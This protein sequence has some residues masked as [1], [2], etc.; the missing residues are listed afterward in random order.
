MSPSQSSLGKATF[1]AKHNSILLPT[2]PQQRG[3]LTQPSFHCDLQ[4]LSC[5]TQKNY[6]TTAT[7]IGAP[8]PD[9][10]AHAQKRR[11]W[12]WS[13]F[14]KK[15]SKRKIISAKMDKNLLPKAFRNFHATHYN[16]ISTGTCKRPSES[17][18]STG[19]QVPFEKPWRSHSTAICTDCRTQ[20][21]CNTLLWNTSLAQSVSTHAK[22]K[23]T[24]STKKEKKSP[25]TLSYIAPTVRDSSGRNRRQSADA[26]N[27]RAREPTFLRSGTSV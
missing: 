14:W 18:A 5:E 6:H 16:T 20:K 10:E 27:R 1:P 4:R 13:T 12:L 3:T 21:N 24:A 26:R 11:F 23:S 22:H 7:Q 9:P 15:F 2:Q 8:K 19:E 17:H 25:G